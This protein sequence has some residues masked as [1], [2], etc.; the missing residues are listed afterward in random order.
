MLTEMLLY[1]YIVGYYY[2]NGAVSVNPQLHNKRELC[3]KDC[4]KFFSRI[5]EFLLTTND[6]EGKCTSINTNH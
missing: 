1:D 5:L 6:H 3:T 2:E 4:P